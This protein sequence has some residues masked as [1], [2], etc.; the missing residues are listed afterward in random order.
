MFWND[1]WANFLSDMLAGVILGGFIAAYIQRRQQ[2]GENLQQR[3]NILKLLKYEIEKNVQNAKESVELLQMDGRLPW[4][5]LKTE[6]WDMY[7]GSGQLNWLSKDLVLLHRFS[8]GYH[9]INAV[10]QIE[11]LYLELRI[12]SMG[13]ESHEGIRLLKDELIEGY[14]HFIIAAERFLLE[15][16]ISEIDTSDLHQIE[17][18][19]ALG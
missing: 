6:I 14:E 18:K 8:T 7:A 4:P 12:R 9:S 1:F 19:T 16:L 5:G 3:Q 15:D 2:H 10:R 13:W 17:L 11:D